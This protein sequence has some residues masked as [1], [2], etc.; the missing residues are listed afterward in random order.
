MKPENLD[1][2]N[3][4]SNLVAKGSNLIVQNTRMDFE[5][6]TYIS[7]LWR[8]DKGNWKRFK[9]GK[10]NFS[11]PKFA[12]ETN[13]IFYVKTN[14]SVQDKSKSKKTSSTIEMQLGR[15]LSSIFE[16]EGSINNYVLSSN[17]KFLYVITSEWNEEFKNI[18]IKDS[19]PM[20]YESLPFR[21]DTKGIIYN[22]RGSI[23]KVNLQSGKS[24]KVVDGDK[25]NI[26]SIDSLVEN[27][28]V[29]TF[30][31][32]KHNSKGTMLEERIGSLKNKKIVDIFT[33]GMLGNLFY[34]EDELHAVGLKNR[35]EWPTNTTVLRLS[36]SGKVSFKYKLFDRNIIKAKVH[37]SILYFLYEDSGKTLL[38]N[39]N[40]KIDLIDEN[41]TIKDFAFSDGSVYVIANSF[42]NPDEVYELI[43]GKLN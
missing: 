39:G 34:Y 12:K 27:N 13:A 36:Q 18:E 7:E 2:F 21:F 19:E 5:T 43:E 20:Y 11:N 29:L 8:M 40:E 9:S 33:K 14:R 38:R 1:S 4:L 26:I 22:K 30:V 41:I 35:F 31:Y 25:H 32:N 42:S 10:N 3:T 28:G 6:N 16:I 24:E 17:E 15:S 37:E 23:Y